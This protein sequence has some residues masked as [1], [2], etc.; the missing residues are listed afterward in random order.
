M[1][2]RSM[3]LN[4]L[5]TLQVLLKTRSVTLASKE[6]FVAQP[7][8]SASLKQL[9]EIFDDALLERDSD[10]L[11]KLTRKAA[12]IKPKLDQLLKQTENLIGLDAKTV[13]PENLDD[14][15]HLGI[16][17][18]VGAIIFPKLY[19]V[20]SNIAPSVKVKQTDIT[21]LSKLSAKELHELD[22]IIGLFR[23]TPKNY[24]RECYFSDQ[25]ICLSGNKTLNKKT[26]ITIKDLNT[27]EHVILSYFCDFKNK[28]FGEEMLVTHNVQRKFKMIVSDAYLAVQLAEAYSLLLLVM[29]RR[30]ELL[31]KNYQ[32]KP[33]QLPFKST[34]I[35]T[36]ILQKESD[37]QNPVKQWFKS[38]LFEIVK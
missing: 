13:S 7:S 27:Y 36:D 34:K 29:K 3:N 38:V 18:H 6:L 26:K 21:D 30:A 8:V 11:F 16:Q 1:N 2:L 19:E 25:Y 33:F 31:L 10:G 17:T 5:K 32:L 4:L 28:S 20:L 24:R 15:F 37:E 23:E 9:R 35:Q 14:T 22:F 12:L